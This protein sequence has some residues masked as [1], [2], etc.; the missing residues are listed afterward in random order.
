MAKKNKDY[1]TDNTETE[2]VETVATAV[3][4]DAV[5]IN[6]MTDDELNAFMQERREAKATEYAI[7]EV[8]I[9]MHQL[10]KASAIVPQMTQNESVLQGCIKHLQNRLNHLDGDKK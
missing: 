3:E 2:V 10:I 4:K 6:E 8:H 9:P 5:D 7:K 1:I